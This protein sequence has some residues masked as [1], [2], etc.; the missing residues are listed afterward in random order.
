MARAQELADWDGFKQARR[1]SRKRDGLLRGI[2]IATYIEACGNNGP[3]TATLK[4]EQDGGVTLLIGSQSTGQGHATAYAQLVA[5]QLG[6]PPERVRMVQGDTDRI[7]TGAGTGGS[8]SIPVGGV[9]RRRAPPRSSADKLK[10]LAADALEA[11]AGDLEIVDGAVRVAGTDRAIA[12]ADLAKRP[13]ATAGQ[14]H[15]PRTTSAPHGADLSERHAYRRGRDRPGDRRDRDRQLCHRRRFRR[16][17]QSAAAR[18]PGAWRRGAG[19]RPGADGGH[20]LRRGLRP[21]R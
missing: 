2:G 3:E 16:D 9:S 10:E 20:G 6:L 21:A 4:L 18:R 1:R 17:A 19:H 12:F 11:S 8:S 15:A 5:E 13:E 7:E 14:A